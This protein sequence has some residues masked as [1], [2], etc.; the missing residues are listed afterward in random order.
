VRLCQSYE[1]VSVGV[2][3]DNV[4][5]AHRRRRI[6]SPSSLATLR[7]PTES[8]FW[9]T[10]HALVYAHKTSVARSTI[11]IDSQMRPT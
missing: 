9:F 2:L 6:I 10:R 3:L 11:V 4:Y 1:Q 5:H 8:L 7:R